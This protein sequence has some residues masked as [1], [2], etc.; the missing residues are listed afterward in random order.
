MTRKIPKSITRSKSITKVSCA[1]V[2][3]FGLSL[4]PHLLSDTLD[5]IFVI[6]AQLNEQA[7][8]SQAKIDDISDQTRSLFNDYKTVLREIE[9][10]RVYNAQL[11]R[12]IRGQ[13]EQMAQI[14][15]S[16]DRV[17][18]TQRQI[19]PLML[20]M[21]DGLEQFVS[22]DLPFLP[23]E[24]AA[25]IER[26]RDMMDQANVAV[27]EK[28]SQVLN[29]YQIENEYGR[30]ME[31][32]SG[33]VELNGE[34]RV[35]D[36][37]RFGRVVLAFQSPDGDVTGMWNRDTQQWEEIDDSYATAVRNGIRMARKQLS[38]D[39]LNLPLVIDEKGAAQ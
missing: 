35:A 9:G 22:L 13:E 6:S 39:L 26:L 3:I 23:E 20:R 31:A 2:A 4:S 27:S 16:I 29:A 37:F 25:R 38:V 8:Q 32:Y 17:T 19:T 18:A 10:L 15:D 34:E 24:R 21:I 12:Q 14:S 30:T 28:L 33:T 1:L 36:L 5:E 11:S 7:R